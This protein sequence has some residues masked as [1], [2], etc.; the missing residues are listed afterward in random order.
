MEQ[1]RDSTTWHHSS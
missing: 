1:C